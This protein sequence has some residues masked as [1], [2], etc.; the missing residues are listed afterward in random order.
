MEVLK[1]W[2]N[3]I[4]YFD[5]SINNDINLSSNKITFFTANLFEERKVPTIVI[6]P[7]GGYG[8]RASEHEGYQI[9]GYFASQGFN[10]A[11]VE[12]RV[13]PY[14]YP[15]PLLDAQRAIKVLRYNADRLGID[16]NKI[17]TL[18]FSAG[19]HLCGM[20]ATKPDICKVQADEI[21]KMS[22]KVNGAILC[23]PVV[24]STEKFSHFDSIKNL[25][26]GEDENAEFSNERNVTPD[27]CPCFIWHTAKDDAVNVQNSFAFAQSLIKNN[28]PCEMHIY[29]F[30]RHGLGL[31]LTEPHISSWIELAAKWVKDIV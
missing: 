31:G 1:I 13:A 11:V 29:P 12:Y 24:S 10:A 26:G 17:V 18:G 4:P 7:G 2:D 30:G 27:T 6:F 8:F 21:D 15:V 5:K 28:V 19:G 16:E 3:E 22:A 14:R 23:Y 9:A 25:L 20:T